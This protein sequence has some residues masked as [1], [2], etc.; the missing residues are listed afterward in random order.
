MAETHEHE[1]GHHANE[2]WQ[3]LEKTI[4]DNRNAIIGGLVVVLLVI[5]GLVGYKQLFIKPREAQAVE[6]IAAPQQAF[7]VDSFRLALEGNAFQDGFASLAKKYGAAPSG[8]LAHGYAAI[9]C[10]QL[11][12]Y[13][14][15]ITH[16][17]KFD[18]KDDLLKARVLGVMGHAYS[19]KGDFASAK[20]QYRKAAEATT[21]NLLAPEYHYLAG[22]AAMETEAFADAKRHF[23]LIKDEYPQSQEGRNIDKFLALADAKIGG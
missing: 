16:G 18:S 10:L 5:G 22:L 15:A 19:E 1:H 2:G 7:A 23:Q 13:D 9:C 6:R 8:K 11:G 17:K 3:S 14:G 4:M 20:Q 12:D 21:N